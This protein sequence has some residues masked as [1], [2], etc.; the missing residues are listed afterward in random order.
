MNFQSQS[1]SKEKGITLK[2][3]EDFDEKDSDDEIGLL[4]RRFNK[5]LRNESRQTNL[6]TDLLIRNLKFNKR[7]TMRK[8]SLTIKIHQKDQNVKNV[9]E[10]IIF[11]L[12]WKSQEQVE[13]QI[14][15]HY[16]K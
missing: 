1:K 16:S 9:V 11:M 15:Q 2:V 4:I 3:K 12:R 10:L 13:E 8:N 7:S 5:I 6:S 14:L